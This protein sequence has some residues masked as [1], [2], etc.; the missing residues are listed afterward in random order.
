MKARSLFGAALAFGLVV[1]PPDLMAQSE[2]E[3]IDVA[4]RGPQVG[5]TIPDF[6]LRDQFGETWTRDS[7]LSEN[8]TML[9]FIRSADW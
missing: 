7:I 4:E 8:G 2:R 9:V 3:V 6:T 5:E 1:S